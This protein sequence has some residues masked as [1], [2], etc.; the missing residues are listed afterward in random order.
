[1]KIVGTVDSKEEV[2]E[3]DRITRYFVVA[4]RFREMGK[5][6]RKKK[7]KKRVKNV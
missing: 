3:V 6:A 5:L 2:K 1:M 4:C 7:I